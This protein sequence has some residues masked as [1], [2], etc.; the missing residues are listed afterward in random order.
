[1][2]QKTIITGWRANNVFDT[3]NKASEFVYN[4]GFKHTDEVS[5]YGSNINMGSHLTYAEHLNRFSVVEECIKNQLFIIRIMLVGITVVSTSIGFHIELGVLNTTPTNYRNQLKRINIMLSLLGTVIREKYNINVTWSIYYVNN[6]LDKRYPKR[7]KKV[8]RPRTLKKSRFYNYKD[9]YNTKTLCSVM[10]L[11][12]YGNVSEIIANI[13]AGMLIRSP[14]HKTV[15]K[16]INKVLDKYSFKRRGMG[17]SDDVQFSRNVYQGVSVKIKGTI[18]GSR[19]TITINRQ[20]GKMTKSTMS[21]AIVSSYA[22]S[23]TTT[24]TRGVT[25]SFMY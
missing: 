7:L 22:Q 12:A 5:L 6:E 10:C 8:V 13:I 21:S 3:V 2:G 20:R 25:V 16:N 11:S 14:L 19:R 4:T 15:I 17:N 24:G 23:K 18:S 1:M 9:M